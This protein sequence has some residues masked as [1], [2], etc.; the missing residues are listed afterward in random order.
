MFPFRKTAC[1]FEKLFTKM[2]ESVN[3][4]NYVKANF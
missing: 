2:K 4:H 3:N 1:L